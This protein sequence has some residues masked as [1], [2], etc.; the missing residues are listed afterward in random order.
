[1]L[2]EALE[3]VRP[4]ILEADPRSGDEVLDG[5]RDE[6][7]TGLGEGGD[8]GRDMDRHAPELAGDALGLAG[9]EP[10]SHLQPQAADSVPDGGR[11]RHRPSRSV[12]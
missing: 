12:E 5:A 1:M 8:A 4:S 3:I 6:D 10:R 9:W 11:T 7:L 2:R